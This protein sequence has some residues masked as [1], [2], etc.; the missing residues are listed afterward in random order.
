MK[1]PATL[2]GAAMRSLTLQP[3]A[4]A[5]G[6]K[7]RLLTGKGGGMLGNVANALTAIRYAPE[8]AGV[9]Y[10]NESS[11]TVIAKMPPPFEYSPSTPFAWTDEHDIQTAAWLQHQGVPVNREIAGQAIQ[12][13]AKEHSFHPIQDYL[14][15]LKWDG[16]ARIDDWLTLY[17]G[18][19]PSDYV[20]AVG[21]K[22]LIGGVARVYRPGCKNDTCLILEGPQGSLKSTALRSLADPWFT[23]DMPEL[24]TKDAA[25]QTRGVWLIEIAEL[26]SMTRS[27]VSRV[28]A[29]MSRSVDRFRPPYG[30][31]PMDVPRECIFAGTTNKQD[32]LKDETGGRRFWPVGCGRINLDDLRRDRDQL[33][34]EAVTRYRA[35]ATWWLD[36]KEL[37]DAASSE[38][39]ERYDADPW[40]VL[41]EQWVEGKP[42]VTVEQVLEYCLDKPKKDWSQQDK[43]RIARSLKAL[44][45]ERFQKR[46]DDG[47]REWQY[48]KKSPLSPEEVEGW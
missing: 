25:L 39:Q 21:A 46:V 31:R 5:S 38:Q 26:D 19:D 48:R 24:G 4:T 11:L 14:D 15:S 42:Y 27:E 30:R 45:W 41:I 43:I 3:E 37:V 18:V 7:A 44:D 33:W 34:A 32:Y 1:N 8:W 28:K 23:D 20:R 13:V 10:F 2:Y 35:G 29:F 16:I 9:L 22:F 12:T 6:W 36:R 40:Q 47:R 17:I